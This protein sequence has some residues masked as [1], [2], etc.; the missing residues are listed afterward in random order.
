MTLR[1]TLRAAT[2]QDHD[3]V[4][5][6]GG[7][8]DLARQDDYQAFLLAHAAVLPALELD[9]DAAP[10]QHLPPAWPQRR[11]S[12]AL[13]ADLALLGLSPPPSTI[14]VT[15]EDRATRLG[16]LYVLEG[17]RL[18]GAILRR[19]LLTSQP[20][21]PD[22]YLAHGEGLGHWRSFVDW[23]D[24]QT[25]DAAETRAAIGGARQVFGAFALAFQGA[26]AL[27]R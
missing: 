14:T 16:A 17:S 2:R 13:A 9:L 5:Q 3:R 8:F 26:P 1:T 25:V 18:G 7:A 22:G 12:G 23:L 27:V 20:G 4:D 6:L 15:L 11:R 21:A 24:V 19:R 10:A